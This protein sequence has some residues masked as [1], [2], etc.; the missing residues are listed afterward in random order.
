MAHRVYVIELAPGAGRR[1]DPRL[2][3]LYVGSSA[4]DP[5]LR[6]AQ[7]KRGYRSA[8][9]VKR[10]ALRLRPD[11]YEDLSGF[12]GSKAALAAERERARELA[13]CGFVAHCDGTSYG[14]RA[15]GRRGARGGGGDGGWREWDRERLEPVIDHLDAAI[16]ELVGSSFEPLDADRCAALLWGERAF[17]VRDHIDQED[18]PP[19]YGR[20][21]HVRR[22][23]LAERVEELLA[24]GRLRLAGGALEPA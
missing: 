14:A 3:W 1:R 20:F 4:R 17:W 16:A 15:G 19:A 5:D 24:A 18:P 12:R 7:H 8:G 23:V 10:H 22:G 21:A 11:L 6:L 2:P 9:I 13:A